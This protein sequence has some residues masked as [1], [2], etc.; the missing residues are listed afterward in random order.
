MNVPR[1]WIESFQIALMAARVKQIHDMIGATSCVRIIMT[2]RRT[3]ILRKTP[4]SLKKDFMYLVLDVRNS[5]PLYGSI[6][7]LKIL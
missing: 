2:S 6:Y 7:T 3:N 5:E 4:C 1:V